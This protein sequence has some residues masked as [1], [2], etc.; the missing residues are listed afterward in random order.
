M[1]QRPRA[2]RPG[3]LADPGRVGRPAWAPDVLAVVRRAALP[4]GSFTTRPLEVVQTDGRRLA[5][6][7]P[8]GPH[9]GAARGPRRRRLAGPARGKYGVAGAE[10]DAA[11]V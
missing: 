10:R 9:D 6:G 3:A 8:P 2:P 4:E 1:D 5:Q 11:R 7:N